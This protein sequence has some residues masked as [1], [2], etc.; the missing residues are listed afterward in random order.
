M[1]RIH[2]CAHANIM[3]CI[4][5]FTQNPTPPK[6]L[7]ITKGLCLQCP[8]CHTLEG[9][10]KHAE[11][12]TLESCPVLAPNKVGKSHRQISKQTLIP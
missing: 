9:C 12:S 7:L 4:Y 3:C 10:T 2:M 11:A 1:A 8:P 5:L 6:Y